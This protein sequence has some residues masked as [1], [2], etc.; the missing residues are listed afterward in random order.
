MIEADF[1]KVFAYM[2]LAIAKLA[3]H[4]RFYDRAGKIGVDQVKDRIKNTKQDPD[5]LSWAPRKGDKTHPLL[6]NT[7]DL[8]ASI[9][10][11]VGP[12]GVTISPD[13]D[14]AKYLQLGTSKMPARPFMGWGA[15]DQE[16]VMVDFA[17]W[18]NEAIK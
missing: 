13:V 5:G 17:L 15:K 9:N 12:S 2:N 6:Y 7:G 1:S 18:V 4:Q 11:T 10:K 16:A 8:F 14:Y 3:N